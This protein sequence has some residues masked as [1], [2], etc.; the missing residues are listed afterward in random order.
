MEV[1]PQAQ[2][3]L[4]PAGW[5]IRKY[6]LDQLLPAL[7]GA[8]L[9]AVGSVCK[10][11]LSCHQSLLKHR[12]ELI[13]ACN[14]K[15]TVKSLSNVWHWSCSR[16]AWWKLP[17]VQCVQQGI[18]PLL[19]HSSYSTTNYMHIHTATHTFLHVTVTQIKTH[20]CLFCVLM[21]L[22]T[23]CMCRHSFKVYAPKLRLDTRRHVSC[24]PCDWNHAMCKKPAWR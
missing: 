13:L 16:L 17:T 24:Q 10:I 9:L 2:W 1:L 3:A 12:G 15:R 11:Y 14:Y 4:S 18:E 21:S 6:M 23:H 19:A 8:V 5:L 22:H 7:H 20:N